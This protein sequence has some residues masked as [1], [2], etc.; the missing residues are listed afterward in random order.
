MNRVLPIQREMGNV[1]LY[2]ARVAKINQ[3]ITILDPRPLET[4]IIQ[5]TNEGVQAQYSRNLDGS[6]FLTIPRVHDKAT[7]IKN[8]EHETLHH[9]Y[10]NLGEGLPSFTPLETAKA[11]SVFKPSAELRKIEEA[12]DVPLWYLDDVD[13]LVPNSF[14][15]ARGLGI[16]KFQKYP[17]Q[18]VFK[19]MLDGYKGSKSFVKDALKLNTPRDYKRAWDMLSGVRLGLVGAG[20]YTLPQVIDAVP[21]QKYGGWLDKYQGDKDPSQVNKSKLPPLWEAVPGLYPTEQVAPA[22]STAVNNASTNRIGS[23]LKFIKQ[24]EDISRKTGTPK[25]EV[26]AQMNMFPAIQQEAE[27]VAAITGE[28]PDYYQAGQNLKLNIRP[29]FVYDPDKPE[30]AA[31]LK[32]YREKYGIPENDVSFLKRFS[33]PISQLQYLAQHG[34]LPNAAQMQSSDYGNIYEGALSMWNPASYIASGVN[35]G[36][37]LIEG[38]YGTAA[39]DVMGAIPGYY[40]I[41]A[42][43]RAA[44]II[45]KSANQLGNFVRGRRAIDLPFSSNAPALLGSAD[46]VSRLESEIATNPQLSSFNNASYAS[47]PSQSAIKYMQSKGLKPIDPSS[48]KFKE[49][50]INME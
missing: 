42:I 14:D 28:K 40:G 29:D 32:A 46:D 35:A 16:E 45:S 1:G 23:D 20:A 39:L 4:K 48:K 17:G 36:S 13:E 8:V 12:N 18:E 31:R 3:P 9:I 11:K 49:L 21:E 37:N 47:Y 34:Q 41:Q 5:G 50:E 19:K 25:E 2:D 26:I 22:V 44:P 38:N 30:T 33:E 10:P 43:N 24:A 6:G 27:R 7:A 15:L